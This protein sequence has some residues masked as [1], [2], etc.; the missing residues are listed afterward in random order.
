[1][2]E[3]LVIHLDYYDLWGPYLWG[4]YSES[5]HS[6]LA[7]EE[8]ADSGSE[9]DGAHAARAKKRPAPS[10]SG[11]LPMAVTRPRRASMAANN[12]PRML[13]N[14]LLKTTSGD[15][16]ST[17]RGVSSMPPQAR[18]ETQARFARPPSLGNGSRDAP[19]ITTGSTW[20][21]AN[22]YSDS[23]AD[24]EGGDMDGSDSASEFDEDLAESSASGTQASL[25]TS[26]HKNCAHSIGSSTSS[27]STR[28]NK[29]MTIRSMDVVKRK[30]YFKDR[31]LQMKDVEKQ[32][33]WCESAE[34]P[35]LEYNAVHGF[36]CAICIAQPVSVRGN[37]KLS[38]TGYGPNKPI[39][40]RSKLTVH[41]KP[42][43]PH[44]LCRKRAMEQGKNSK[45]AE[46]LAHSDLTR[47]CVVM[48]LRLCAV[49]WLRLC[50]VLWQMHDSSKSRTQR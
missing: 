42:G 45:V 28:H 34:F 13:E 10:D 32:K 47:T 11:E 24:N 39:S 21:L 41:V 43:A 26:S 33:K 3:D 31:N 37:D 38:I 36:H 23:S 20:S 17:Q 1:M 35:W 16:V 9:G 5:S 14:W 30:E 19:I 8:E 4:P 12:G 7:M 50:A 49:L 48:R 6:R 29:G 27:N 22:V 44:H 15:S 18:L 40:H 2:L 25:G 46:P